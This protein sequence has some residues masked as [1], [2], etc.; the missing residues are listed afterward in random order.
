M[1]PSADLCRIQEAFQRRRAENAPL[2][3]VRMIAEKA[4]AAWGVEARFAEGREDRQ[5]QLRLI[6]AG[7]PEQER[8]ACEQL[9]RG[10]NE[11]PD[12]DRPAPATAQL[13]AL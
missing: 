1:R 10:I 4:A 9:D 13:R 6:G 12:R 5:A 11:N 3:N 7:Q 8:L 2:G